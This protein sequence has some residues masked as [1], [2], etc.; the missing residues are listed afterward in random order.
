MAVDKISKSTR[1]IRENFT[2]PGSSLAAS[3]YYDVNINVT[4]SG[5]TPIGVSNWQINGTTR[6]ALLYAAFTTATNLRLRIINASDASPQTFSDGA[7]S[8]LY[9]S[10]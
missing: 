4:K 2:F 6:C 10:N 7:V 5:Y 9:M 1:I 8:V 3:A